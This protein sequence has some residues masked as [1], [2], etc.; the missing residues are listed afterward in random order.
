[1]S[2]TKIEWATT[3]WN[4]VVGCKKISEGCANC[5]AERMARRFWKAWGCDEPPNHFR[6]RF[7]ERR[8]FEP[9]RWRKP[10]RVFVCSV[11]DLFDPDHPADWPFSVMNEAEEVNANRIHDG[12]QPHIFM[13]LTKRPKHMAKIVREW[14]HLFGEDGVICE[15][16]QFWFGTTV[17]NQAAADERIPFLLDIEAAVRFVSYEPAIGGLDLH[18]YLNDW[19]WKTEERLHGL[20]WVI[21]GGETG[22]GARP[23]NPYWAKKVKDDCVAAGVPFFFKS[24]GEY[25][26]GEATEMIVME[27]R[28]PCPGWCAYQNGSLATGCTKDWGGGAVSMKVGKKNAGAEL[29]GQAWE[30]MPHTFER[31]KA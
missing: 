22:P 17:E 26:G 27:N 18:P 16:R 21:C 9:R 3:S 14:R 1:M 7:I 19:E 6:P 12:K 20:D 23:M 30:Q 10:R 2:E 13:F 5:Y 24:W 29:D 28:D 8:L 31:S 11:S 4:P 15:D 25:V